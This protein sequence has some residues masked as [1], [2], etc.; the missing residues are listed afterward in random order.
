MNSSKAGSVR[1]HKT[2]E[3]RQQLLARYHQS[4]QTQR[5]FVARHGIGLSTLSKWLRRERKQS[6]PPVRF[7]EVTLP[8]SPPRWA[9]EIVSPHGW[10]VRVQT[11]AE[12]QTLP[13]LLRAVPC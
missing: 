3:Q 12:V 8:N 5:Q 11:S 1:R 7:Q 13:Q 2:F 9:V 10:V 6:L 4:Q